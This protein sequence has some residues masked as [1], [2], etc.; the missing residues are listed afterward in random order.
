MRPLYLTDS[1]GLTSFKVS[2]HGHGCVTH[3]DLSYGGP[4]GAWGS[5]P[6]LGPARERDDHIEVFTILTISIW[7]ETLCTMPRMHAVCAQRRMQ[8]AHCQRVPRAATRSRSTLVVG[9]LVG[10]PGRGARFLFLGPP[11]TRGTTTP[12]RS[13]RVATLSPC[14]SASHMTLLPLSS[15]KARA[16]PCRSAAALA[17]AIPSAWSATFLSTSRAGSERVRSIRRRQAVGR[18][19]M[20]GV[21]G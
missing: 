9:Q 20:C 10:L 5:L 14:E 2:T 21:G 4:P 13:R 7:R 8:L 17:A 1:V 15:S 3:T 19:L 16:R 11:G 18:E 12:T 6:F